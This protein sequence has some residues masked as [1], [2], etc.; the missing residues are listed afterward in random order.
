ML[1]LYPQQDENTESKLN[2]G[3]HDKYTTIVYGCP[4][5]GG[6]SAYPL[7]NPSPVRRTINTEGALL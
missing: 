2:L 7:A 1:T 3:S 4:D 6:V 5:A